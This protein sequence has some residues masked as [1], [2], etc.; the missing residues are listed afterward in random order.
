MPGL[1]ESFAVLRERDFRLVLGAQGASM[2]G[3]RMVVV[4]LAFA[5]L[6]LGGSA[7]EVGL[8][9][10]S[11]TLPLVACLLAGGVVADRTSPRG[12][13]VAADLV[14]LASQ[15][16]SAALLI[17]GGAEIW[18]LAVLAGA[19]GAAS[20]FFNPASIGLLPAVVAPERLMQANGVRATALGAGEILGPALAGILVAAVGPGWALAGD[21]ATFALSA[22]L[23]AG[24]RVPPRAARATASFLEDLRGGWAA[25]RERRWVWSFVASVAVGNML[26]G[27]WG[28]LGPVVADRELGGAAAWGAVLAT[29]GVG[30]LLGGVLVTRVEPRRPMLVVALTGAVFALPL[31]LLA[32]QVPVPVLAAGALFSGIALMFGNAMWESTLQRHIPL[33][34]LSRVSAYDWFGSLAFYPVGVLLWGPLSEAIGISSALWLAFGLYLVMVGVMISIPDIRRL[35]PRPATATR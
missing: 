21:A 33:E 11:G 12:V 8:V 32:A 17:T 4:A 30:G 22:V 5:V 34:S 27:A 6:E 23:L 9:L 31:A 1:P 26:W 10:A 20:G 18:T 2:L 15:G 35:G 7:T 25:F 14:R 29:M 16:L 28:T 3:D 24:V 13:M 19:T